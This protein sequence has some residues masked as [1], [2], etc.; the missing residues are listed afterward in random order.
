MPPIDPPTTAAQR[1]IP[2]RSASAASIPTWSRIVTVGK[3]EPYGRPSAAVDAGPVVPWQP[4]STLG[5]ITK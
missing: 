2:S 5:Q 1:R 3:R 4:P